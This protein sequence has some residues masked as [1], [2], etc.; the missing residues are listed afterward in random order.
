MCS[1]VSD[2]A[3]ISAMKS[4]TSRHVGVSFSLFCTIWFAGADCRILSLRIVNNSCHLI[5]FYVSTTNVI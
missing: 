2:W 4:I 1:N 5:T 3:F